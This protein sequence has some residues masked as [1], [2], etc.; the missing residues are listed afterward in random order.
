MP[1]DLKVDTKIMMY[2]SIAKTSNPIPIYF[3]MLF[4]KFIRQS[5]GGFAND[6]KIADY[7]IEIVF[8]SFVK[9]SKSI[10]AV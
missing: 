9:E 8:S 6:L 7:G 3:T 2:N 10:P 1:D 5:I 4:S